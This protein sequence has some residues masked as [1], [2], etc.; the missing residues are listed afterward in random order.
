M[1]SPRNVSAEFLFFYEPIIKRAPSNSCWPANCCLYNSKASRSIIT[2][3]PTTCWP[4]CGQSRS[5]SPP[6]K[7]VFYTKFARCSTLSRCFSD[8]YPNH[9]GLLADCCRPSQ[10][11]PDHSKHIG[12]IE[13]MIHRCIAYNHNIYHLSSPICR[14]YGAPNIRR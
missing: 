10:H 9:C 1:V 5:E 14:K 4:F 2:G 8:N 13:P 6:Q 11:V 7:L 12:D 3:A